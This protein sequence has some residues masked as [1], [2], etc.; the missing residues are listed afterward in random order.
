MSPTVSVVIPAHNAARDLPRAVQSALDQPAA[1]EVIVV[2][3]ASRDATLAVARELAAADPRVV[4]IAAPRNLGPAGA[5]NLGLDAAHGTWIA[6]LDSDDRFL[7]SRFDQLLGFAKA[8]E[9]DLLA[10]NLWLRTKD[11]PGPDTVMLPAALVPRPTS[12]DAA[13]FLAGNLPVPGHPRVSYGFLKPLIRRSFLESRKLR[14]RTW[15][16]FGEDF[17]LYLRCLLAGGR[18]WLLPAP[19]YAYTI[20]GNSL[21]ARHSGRDLLH[22]RAVDRQLLRQ[23][24]YEAS[25]TR[26]LRRHLRSLDRRAVR[27]LFY[28]AMKRRDRR[29]AYWIASRS[30][31]TGTLVLDEL[32]RA[33]VTRAHHLS[34]R[35]RQF[36]L[37]IRQRQ[38]IAGRH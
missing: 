37:S 33:L 38:S 34:R 8:G 1:L 18:A 35:I 5:R 9:A 27:Q 32:G 10:D 14:Y 17:D 31:W 23:P 36:A 13:A 12:L 15:L 28:E 11:G 2:D 16:R 6:L 20:H 19:G 22:L 30:L 7:T 4:P 3:D 26:A 25:T 29:R 24:A 21:T